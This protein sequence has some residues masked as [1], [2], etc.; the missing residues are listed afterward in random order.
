MARTY[1]SRGGIQAGGLAYYE[2]LL[3]NPNVQRGLAVIRATEGTAKSRTPYNM[4]FGMRP[5][6]DLSWHPGKSYKFTQTNGKANRTTAAGAYQFLK[7]TWNSVAKQLGLKSFN[8]KNQDIAALA[9]IDRRGGLGPLVKGDVR[10]FVKAV[11]PEWASLP[12]APDAYSQPKVGWGKVERAWNGYGWDL[13][14]TAPTPNPKQTPGA[15]VAQQYAEY[16]QSRR[17]APAQPV[18]PPLNNAPTRTAPPLSPVDRGP[19]LSPART[20]AASPVPVS[21]NY[22]QLGGTRMALA[23]TPGDRLAPAPA[24]RLGPAASPRLVGTTPGETQPIAAS[25]YTLGGPVS[26]PPDRPMPGGPIAGSLPQQ[27]P[28][29]PLS[30]P[31]TVNAPPPVYQT[32]APLNPAQAAVDAAPYSAPEPSV[33]RGSQAAYDFYNGMNDQAVASTGEALNRDPYGR[34]YITNKYGVTTGTDARGNSFRASSIPGPLGDN[35]Q[36]DKPS[37][38]GADWQDMGQKARPILGGAIGGG[39]GGLLGPA[40]AAL[41]GLLGKELSKPGGGRVG[42]FIRGT[43]TID[44]SLVPGFGDTARFARAQGGL[45]FPNAPSGGGGTQKYSDRD[46]SRMEKVSPKAARDIKSGKS[47]LY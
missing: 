17:F 31:Q 35:P 30:A 37:I 21:R 39:L 43:R 25:H 24:S 44:T 16:A 26:L 9:L 45:A 2:A 33:P 18:S 4:A 19:A 41:G 12:T 15:P 38:L 23:P 3:D 40:G 28:A 42:D 36:Q 14:Q 6:G 47:G 29:P 10:G 32:P 8:A 13:P 20:P 22:P 27:Q 1:P 11:G 34:T 7:G 5:I 46:Y